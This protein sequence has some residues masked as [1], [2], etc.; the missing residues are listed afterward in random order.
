MYSR[1]LVGTSTSALALYVSSGPVVA[2]AASPLSSSKPQPPQEALL[3]VYDDEVETVSKSQ[4]GSII[5]SKEATTNLSELEYHATKKLELEEVRAQGRV[6]E[7]SRLL[8]G[9]VS[10]ARSAL[11]S[12]IEQAETFSEKWGHKYRESERSAVEKVANLKAEQE[13]LLPESIYVLIAGLSGSIAARR[14]N[15]LVRGISPLL[16]GGV[17]FAYFLPRTWN[18]VRQQT[19]RLEEEQLPTLAEKHASTQASLEDLSKQSGEV[20]QSSKNRVSEAV[21]LVRERIRQWIGK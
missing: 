17:A 15:I 14:C 5:P 11:N 20:Y 3:P 10:Q 18:N 21:Q 4:L 6:Y 9:Y 7:I 16:F 2:H 13:D 1:F 12:G 19:W 8:Q